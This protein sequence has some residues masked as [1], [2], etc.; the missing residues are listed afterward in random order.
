MKASVQEIV[1]YSFCPKLFE[2]QGDF[3]VTEEALKA[4]F[5]SLVIFAFRKKMEGDAVTWKHIYNRWTKIFWSSHSEEDKSN[6]QKF[7]KS[8]IGIKAFYEWWIG[9]ESNVLAVNFS[10]SGSIYDHQVLGEIPVVLDNGDGTTTLVFVDTHSKLSEASWSPGVRYPSVVLDQ[11]LPVGS[12]L[13]LSLT[14][15]K[16]F[17]HFEIVPT[18]RYWEGSMQDLIG[19]LQSMHEK[20]SYPNTLACKFCPLLETCEAL[21]E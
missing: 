5:L 4:C 20:I 14:G 11:T 12:V 3:P 19:V 1:R 21:N 7:N 16:T 6:Q 18:P 13:V 15:Y 10:M 2:Q 17:S 8:L 9:F